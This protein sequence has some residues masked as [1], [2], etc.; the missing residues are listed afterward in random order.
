MLGFIFTGVIVVA[1]FSL[2][3]LVHEA[4]HFLM[5]RRMGVKVERLP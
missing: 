3:I 4:G 5:A 2:V 1:V